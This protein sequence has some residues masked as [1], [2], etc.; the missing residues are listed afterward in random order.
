MSEEIKTIADTMYW[1]AIERMKESPK[2][3]DP[4]RVVYQI[5]LEVVTEVG[6]KMK[7]LR[8]EERL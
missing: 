7:S 6:K 1:M 3:Q 2:D 5:M 4:V 8:E